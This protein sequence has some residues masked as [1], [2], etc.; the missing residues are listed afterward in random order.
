MW[1]PTAWLMNEQVI[2]LIPDDSQGQCEMREGG[3][4]RDTQW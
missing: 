4:V 1:S 3:R 2:D